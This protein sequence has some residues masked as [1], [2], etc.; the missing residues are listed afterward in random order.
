MTEHTSLLPID[1]AKAQDFANRMVGALNS[2]ALS[3]MTSLGHRTGLF[4]TLSA[5]PGAT[6]QEL[7]DQAGLTERY[8][9]EWLGVMVTS[10]VVEYDPQKRS[11]TL[12]P[13]HAAF[14]TRAATPNN[15]AVTSQ[16]IG[17]AA[18]VEE[19]ML[20]RFQDGNGTHYHHY[21]RFHAVMAE[22]S[23]QTVG[24]ALMDHI[25]PIVPGLRDRLQAG[26]NVVDAGCGGGRAMLL[27]AQKFPTSR[28]TGIDLCAD[29]FADSAAEAKRLG[30][31]NLTFRAQD[32][33]EVDTL[34][35]CD[36]ITAFDA[37]HDQRDPQGL[38]DLIF[39]SLKPG[40][41][42][43]MQDIG[44]SRDLEINKENPF[45][46]LLYTISLMHCTPISVGQGGPGL[47]AMWG[48]ETAQEF[49][50]SAGFQQV[51]MQRLQHDPINAYFIAR[52]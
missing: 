28:F 4:D 3:L 50:A 30:L 12:P 40:G 1:E 26:I 39:R 29:A 33:A 37:V 27:L 2:A 16:F 11:F 9:R 22:D 46:P 14:L 19:E 18:A 23:A 51:D 13:E 6:S 35:P 38:L 15:I 36:L 52:R 5:L 25:L 8:V 10:D 44:G 41:L 47:G 7:S 17:V 20:A 48:V 24:A 34:E 42:L 31:T 45:A 21:D 49:L 32:L 43:L